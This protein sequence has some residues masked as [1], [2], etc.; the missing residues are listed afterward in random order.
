MSKHTPGPWTDQSP[1]G[2]AWGVY[3]AQGDAVA[4]AFQIRIYSADPY[5][6]ERHANARL[7]AAAPDL[8]AFAQEFLADYQSDDGMASMKKYAGMAYAAIAKATGKSQ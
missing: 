3:S 2:S 5:Q 1:D 8:L 6:K 7:I 4:Q